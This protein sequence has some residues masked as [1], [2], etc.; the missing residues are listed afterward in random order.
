ML[1][2]YDTMSIIVC[3]RYEHVEDVSRHSGFIS[4]G[5]GGAFA[6]P[7]LGIDLSPLAIGFPYI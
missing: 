3:M 2:I 6:P 1:T 4:G 5:Q 7:P